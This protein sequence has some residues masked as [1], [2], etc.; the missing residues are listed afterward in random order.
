[1]VPS[2]RTRAQTEAQEVPAEL[3][4]ELYSEGDRALE[5][6]AQRGCGFSYSGNIQNPP[7]CGPVQAALDEFALGE[8]LD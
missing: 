5:Q 2:D 8:E 3:E 6:A 1:M 7:E 4:E